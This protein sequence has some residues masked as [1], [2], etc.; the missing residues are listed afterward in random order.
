MPLTRPQETLGEGESME[1]NTGWTR[2]RAYMIDLLPEMS[3][4]Q[5][6]LHLPRYLE[7]L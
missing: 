2:R 4:R 1:E 6:R 7:R 5:V 3:G